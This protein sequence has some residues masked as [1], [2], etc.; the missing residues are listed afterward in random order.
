MKA[1]LFIFIVLFFIACDKI[2]QNPLSNNTSAKKEL[3]AKLV[4]TG[5]SGYI[6][7]PQALPFLFNAGLTDTIQ[8][9]V[10]DLSDN[11][12][13]LGKYYKVATTGHYFACLPDYSAPYRCHIIMEIGTDGTL[14]KAERFCYGSYACC[15]EN[16]YDGFKRYGNYFGI[17][18]CGTGTSYCSGSLYLF[19]TVLP[20]D[21]QTPISLHC[22]QGNIGFGGMS[23]SLESDMVFNSENSLTV[24][25]Q[26]EEG[27]VD[28]ESMVFTA[29]TTKRFAFTYQ[30]D[31]CQ[32]L[33]G[34]QAK[35]EELLPMF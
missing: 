11:Q 19:K 17:K 29:K 13:T 25:Y 31:G 5:D 30:F 1:L 8:N 15:W 16:R 6:Y 23:Q 21:D 12:D 32:W 20:Q 18:T 22:W 28:E 7:K 34:D 26:L 33:P 24:H 3:P 4:L 9:N 14:I 2:T 35:V 10:W 27:N